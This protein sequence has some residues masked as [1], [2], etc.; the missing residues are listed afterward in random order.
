M[1]PDIIVGTESWLHLDIKDNEIFPT[2]F[3]VYRRDRNST[4]GGVFTAV[5]N[6][7]LST[8]QSELETESE[9]TWVKLSVKGSKDLYICSYYRPNVSDE[10]SLD[11]LNN[12]LDK[13]CNSKNCHIWLAGDFNL[14]G[15]D[16]STNTIKPYCPYPALHDKFLEILDDYGLTQHVNKP[17]RLNNTLDLF[18]TNNPT[19]INN[20]EV[21]PGLADHNAVLIEDD[22]SPISNKQKPRRIPLFRKADW[23][24]LAAYMQVFSDAATNQIPHSETDDDD[25]DD[26]ESLWQSFKHYLNRGIDKFIPSKTAKEKNR[27]PWINADLKHLIRK[28]NKCFRTK[29]R[30]H[31]PRDIEQHKSLRREVQ[32]KTRQSYW[33]YIN[34]IF[35]DSNDANEHTLSKR[36]WSFIKHARTDKT[37]IS[38]LK[39]EGSVLTNPN[40]K[41]AL[42]NKQFKNAFSTP[43][44]MKLKHI[45]KAALNLQL[46][47]QACSSNMPPIH[48]T[49]EGVRKLLSTLNPYKATGSDS[50]HPRVLRELST[51]I[52]PVLCKIYRS[53][54][55][56]GNVPS[57]WK[58]AYVSPIYKKGSKQQA[59]N[60][61]PISLTCI[62][63]KVLEHI[64]VSNIM[65]HFEKHNILNIFQHGF[66][67]SRSCETQLIGLVQDLAKE[68]QGGGQTDIIVMDFS[69][70]FDKV[71]H[72]ELL[73]KLS[74]YG[75]DTY[76]LNWI[77]N[78]LKNR[79]QCVVLEG[80][81]SNY[82]PV[83]SGVPQG[84]VLGP[85][86]FLAFINDLPLYVKSNVR[87]FADD[88]VIYLTVKSVDDCLQLQQ[89]LH[90]LEIWE[91]D[92]KMKFN[93]SKCNV[94]RF[95]RR[96]HPVLYNYKLHGHYLDTVDSTKYLG[97]H[98]SNDLRWNEHVKNISSKANKTL[99]FLK[100]NLRHC[101]SKT[102][103]TAYRTLIR[104]TIEYCST[105]WDPFTAKNIKSVEMVQRRA[106]RWVLN[107]YDRLDSVND[108]LYCL[109]WKTLQSRRS[110]ARLSMLYKMRNNLTY[111]DKNMLQ[112][113]SYKS[114][115]SSEHASRSQLPV[116]IILNFHF[117]LEHFLLGT[118]SLGISH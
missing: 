72:N 100:R 117:T 99:G 45:A 104:P 63:S 53:S 62:C 10:E 47:V 115:R 40:D 23:D 88:T 82:T 109:N 86:L 22:I 58:S 50:I 30:T 48:I 38:S 37:G 66:R 105:V 15:F 71:P 102:K 59:E 18:V 29:N 52:A 21:L 35:E 25:D 110:I 1:K 57:D 9:M 33:N 83:L 42:L 85:T 111:A 28:R 94:L 70:A 96:R 81:K 77:K 27:L 17:T 64:L 3:N 24:G 73:L 98:L 8:R 14:P 76:T 43:E 6:E 116:V 80:V 61:R 95:T 16:W 39:S 46:P 32:K 7:F 79:K 107:R 75:V 84:S 78:F 4:G 20:I 44:P 90:N 12:S 101:P 103:E 92:W 113:V 69:K 13:I 41:A 34:S 114:T 74:N 55:Q 5:S 36:F 68:M 19:L 89:D 91:S 93:I 97:V 26:V 11:H 106:A 60:Y 108:M 2:N 51:Q 31:N 49:V 56:S 112:P 67:Q 87:L 65:K 54:L 118:S